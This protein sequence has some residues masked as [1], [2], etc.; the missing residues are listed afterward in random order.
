MTRP[1]V[2]VTGASGTVGREVVERLARTGARFRAGYS[3]ETRVQAARGT[4]LDAVLCDFAREDTVAAALSGI[5]RLFLLSGGREDQTALESAAVGAAIAARVEHVV[6]LSVWGATEESFGFARIHRPVERALEASGIGWTFLRPNGFLQNLVTHHRAAVREGV[7]AF[8]AAEVAIS[9]VDVRDVADV[10]AACLVGA[11]HAGRTYELSGAEALTWREIA[12]RLALALGRGVR[13]VPL[14]EAEARAGMLES[15]VPSWLAE[16]LLD[17]S[18]YYR[19]GHAA[20]VTGDVRAVLGRDP[21]AFD[22]FLRDHLPAL[23]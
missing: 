1:R 15:G 17:L 12:A 9:H 23:R 19:A 5:D 21:I 13:Y 2:L 8:P 7:L 18:R 11:G 16:G 6:K 3:R 10:A 14:S 4:G 20:R 22:T